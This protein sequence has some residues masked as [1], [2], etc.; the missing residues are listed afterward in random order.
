M[1]RMDVV[2]AVDV[3]H[4]RA[5]ETPTVAQDFG[6]QAGV[7]RAGHA[8]D[9]VVHGHERLG[10]AFGDAGFEG[11]QI[12]FPEVARR[13]AGVE[14]VAVGLGAAVD[15]VVFHGGYGFEIV[16]VVALQTS[17]E[18]DAEARGEERAFA[19]GFLA[20]AP[21]RVAENVNIGRPDRE[22]FVDLS[23][24]ASGAN[25]GVV[26]GAGFRGDR[27]R[28]AV[29]ERRV[30]GCGK[31]D[32]L[33]K[34]GGNPVAGDAMQGLV[35]PL[36]GGDAESRYALGVHAELVDLIGQREASQEV[37]EAVGEREIGIAEGMHG[38]RKEVASSG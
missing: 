26:F 19:V 30:P 38:G 25:G 5:L 28:D 35:P 27:F 20:A 22:A 18:G 10:A 1:V 14:N 36:V 15:R 33:G 12:S 16:R 7:N 29:V 9:G 23:R 32:G 8:V 6:E 37:V 34:H 2:Y 31:S 3:A 4:H 11:G 13:G 17:A 24:T 21:A